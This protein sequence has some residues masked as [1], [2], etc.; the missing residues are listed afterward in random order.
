M[1]SKSLS[2]NLGSDFHNEQR[3]ALIWATHAGHVHKLLPMWFTLAMWQHCVMFEFASVLYTFKHTSKYTH[4]RTY[5][6]STH[7]FSASNDLVGEVGVDVSTIHRAQ[8]NHMHTHILHLHLGQNKSPNTLS[9]EGGVYTIML[10]YRDFSY[11]RDAVLTHVI[12]SALVNYAHGMWAYH[13]VSIRLTQSSARWD[14]EMQLC[15]VEIKVGLLLTFLESMKA[16]VRLYQKYVSI[17]CV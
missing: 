5:T 14:I 9:N 4:P 10:L 7:T 2:R 17:F 8:V 6:H 11:C 1:S 3:W 15:V 12:L 16:K 13:F